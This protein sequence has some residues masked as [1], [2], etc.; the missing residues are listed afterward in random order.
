MIQER[1]TVI[2]GK[3]VI[4]EPTDTED[5]GNYQCVASN[6]S[7]S[8]LSNE[9]QLSFGYLLD[10]PKSIRD[11]VIVNEYAGVGIECNPP[12]HYPGMTTLEKN[13]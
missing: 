5:N 11:P 13:L 8:I 4:D 10:F 6:P 12:K 9:V 3:M 7:G 1:Y 2:N